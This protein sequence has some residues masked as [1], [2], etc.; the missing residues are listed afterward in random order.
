MNDWITMLQPIVDLG[1]PAIQTAALVLLRV[2]AMVALL[3]AFGDVVVPQ[4]VRLALTV[5]L[6][7]IVA[8]A[9]WQDLPISGWGQAALIEIAAGLALGV[10]LRMLLIALQ[11]AAAMVAQSTSLSQMM[12][13]TGPEPQPAVGHLLTMAALALAMT[14]GLP[15]QIVQY[16]I[17]SYDLIPAGQLPDLGRLSAW[18]LAQVSHGFALAFMLAAPFSIAALLYNL[19]LGVINRAMPALMVSFIGAPAL[20]AGSLA[21]LAVLLPLALSAWWRAVMAYLINPVAGPT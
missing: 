15:I 8:P 10:G 9:V 21:A 2:G 12:G 7:A 1:T 20:A 5:A 18:G 4:R 11:T 16:L 19:A 13:N 17:L 3:P 6:T 14:A